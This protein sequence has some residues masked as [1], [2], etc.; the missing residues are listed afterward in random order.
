MENDEYTNKSGRQNPKQQGQEP[1][2]APGQPAVERSPLPETWAPQEGYQAPNYSYVPPQPQAQPSDQRTGSGFWKV[3]GTIVAGCLTLGVVLG[4]IGVAALSLMTASC[5]ASCSD[6]PIGDSR[7]DATFISSRES[8]KRD[9]E[10]FDALR[11]CIDSLYEQTYEGGDTITPDELRREVEAGSWPDSSAGYGDTTRSTNPQLWVRIA[12]LSEDY[13]EQETGEDWKVLDF[14]YPFPDNGPIPV[15]PVRDEHDSAQTR[16]ICVSG[17]DLGLMAVVDYW[18]WEQPARFSSSVE[19]SRETYARNVED[20]QKL[21]QLEVLSGRQFILSSGDIYL[22]DLGEDDPLRDPDT[23][24]DFINEAGT[25]LDT[26][27]DVSLLVSDA[28]TGLRYNPLSYDYPNRREVDIVSFDT[29]AQACLKSSWEV[30]FDCA[31]GD[32][33]LGGYRSTSRTCEPED[34]YGPLSPAQNDRYTEQW[35]RTDP[36]ATF[37]NSLV[38]VVLPKMEGVTEDQVIAIQHSETSPGS[39]SITLRAWLVVPRGA[40]PEDRN[41]FC[42][43]VDGLRDALWDSMS[44]GIECEGTLSLY[45]RIYV[46]D[47]DT[48]TRDGE[49]ISFSDLRI[50]A[51]EDVSQIE[52]CSF[53][54]LLLAHPSVSLWDT[55]GEPYTT[56]C[57]PSEVGGTISR[58]REWR[59][60]MVVE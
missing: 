27:T 59:Y 1:Q 48:I 4:I 3:F 18:R 57:H 33:L 44:E 30:V 15:P 6:S 55:D 51:Q 21:E 46:I 7:E 11:G 28:P 9:L 37:S 56:D 20:R 17:E 36:G 5:V 38:N 8:S 40:L 50:L 54:I 52:D 35:S 22:W 23:F 24:A 16:L 45:V 60:G 12:E 29:C 43:A 58:S 25:L 32:V 2:Q 53:E 34:L 19:E 39:E 10:T 42:T 13:I 14:A 31:Y 41:G 49:P 26:F 47:A